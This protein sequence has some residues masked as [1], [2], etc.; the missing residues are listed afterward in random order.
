MPY[1][2]CIVAAFNLRAHTL[3]YSNAGHPP[4]V[5]LGP[6]R[7]RYLDQGG[8]PAGLLSSA[9]FDQELLTVH[10]GDVCLLVTDGVTE[11]LD[12]VPLEDRLRAAKV[13]TTSAGELCD[14]V[15]TQALGG[16]GPSG[17]AD[18][19]DDR[20]VV[21]VTVRDKRAGRR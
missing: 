12:G 15:M 13:R 4:G 3:I 21:V 2:T 10:A 1:V 17:D 16:H 14:S 6:A 11:A 9:T 7:T 20:T 19:D 5:L 8:P 18:W